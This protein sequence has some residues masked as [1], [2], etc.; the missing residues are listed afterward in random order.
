MGRGSIRAARAWSAVLLLDATLLAS[1]G[2][3]L[4]ISL[5][6]FK[7]TADCLL[8][9]ITAL[10]DRVDDIDVPKMSSSQ[11]AQEIDQDSATID[12]LDKVLP[13]LD[14]FC[15]A[16][17]IV[18]CVALLVTALLA[19]CGLDGTRREC[20]ERTATRLRVSSKC[21]VAVAVAA[22]L[23]GL[24]ASAACTAAAVI[25]QT[26]AVQT[27]WANQTSSCATYEELVAHD[28]Y[29]Y[30]R[31][32]E[33][34]KHTP[35]LPPDKLAKIEAEYDD[36]VE[37]SQMFTSMCQCADAL[38]PTIQPALGPGILGCA[39]ALLALVGLGCVC[40]AQ[41]CCGVPRWA[42]KGAPLLVSTTS[43]DPMPSQAMA[44]LVVN[45]MPPGR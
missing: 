16:P 31:A 23:I 22:A 40:R 21:C 25:T 42:A 5:A 3:Y 14:V 7:S 36:A 19:L 15:F 44:S 32:F 35:H 6:D 29:E 26:E 34:A 2:A 20:L 39:A 4:M 18:V 28:L 45:A 13:Y 10:L 37:E 11:A 33:V 24:A 1:T 9:N 17:T 30:E 38:L 8:S 12:L 27:E 43:H 41:G